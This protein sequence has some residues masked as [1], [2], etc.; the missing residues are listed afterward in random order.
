LLEQIERLKDEKSKSHKP[1]NKFDKSENDE[2]ISS[3]GTI[4]KNF[5]CKSQWKLGQFVNEEPLV[6]KETQW[7]I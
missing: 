6:D 4:I 1:K 7:L 5:L 3:L 2:E